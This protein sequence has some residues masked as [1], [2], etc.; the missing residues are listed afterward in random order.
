MSL[1]DSGSAVKAMHDSGRTLAPNLRVMTINGESC[2]GS[3]VRDISLRIMEAPSPIT[4]GFID[5][6]E[7]FEYVFYCME[8]MHILPFT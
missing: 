4:M 1:K 5:D 3:G 8:C 6:Q 7:A 2:V